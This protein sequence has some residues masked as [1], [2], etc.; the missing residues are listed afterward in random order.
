MFQND[1]PLLAN[2]RV[3][4]LDS[5]SS[6]QKP[7]RVIDGIK[8]FL[9]HDYANIHR[10]A[11]DLSMNASVL[12]EAAKKRV[13]SFVGAS[14][15]HEVVFT[16]NATY[17]CNL[18]ARSLVKTGLL[19]SGDVVLLSRAEH[20]ANI[21]PWHIIAEEY[22]IRLEW[23]N[24]QADGTLDYADLEAKLPYAQVLAITGASNVTG[25]LLDV[26][27]IQTMM[28]SLSKKP[29][30]IMDGSQRF[31]HIYTD[32]NAAGID[33]FIATG[34][35]IMSDTGIGFFAARKELLKSLIPSFC[36]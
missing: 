8:H 23:V 19:R 1:F 21:V 36:G 10:G 20:H 4:F 5:A 9:E 13:A 11:Y 27:R 16:Y 34:H 32:M 2:S 25:E 26:Q 22:G 28:A 7:A 15:H 6:T 14:S 33:I 3:V 35:K 29:L 18:I 12:Y 31:P 24:L 17:A 30:Y